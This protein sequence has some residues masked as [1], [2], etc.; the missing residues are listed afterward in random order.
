MIIASKKIRKISA[1][2]V[3]CTSLTLLAACS[4]GSD[5]N[6]DSG[7]SPDNDAGTPAVEGNA[8]APESALLGSWVLCNEVGG[9]RVEYEFT[10]TMYSNSVGAGT[11]AG[12]ASAD[13]VSVN[14]GPYE[15]TGTTTSDSGLT[16]S[17]MELTTETI[18][19]S[20]VFESLI[21][22]RF[23]LAFTGTPNELVFSS[24][25]REGEE[26]SLTLDLSSPYVRF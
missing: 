9:L 19:G 8:E 6:N 1:L 21:E 25:T 3:L 14:A 7:V 4:S 15:I 23:R 12:F 17:T 5:S 2:G 10:A 22:T 20:P 18:Q 24:D 16:A 11:C 13:Q 26:R